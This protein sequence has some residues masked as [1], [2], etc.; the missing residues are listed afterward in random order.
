MARHTMQLT[1]GR[2]LWAVAAVA[3]VGACGAENGE[4]GL[5][6]AEERELDEAAAALDEAQIEYENAL[7]SPDQQAS[8]EAEER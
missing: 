6:S 5:T 2:H 1:A 4:Q 3:L 8:G 7:Q